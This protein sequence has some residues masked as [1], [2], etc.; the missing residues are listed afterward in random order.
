MKEILLDKNCTQNVLIIN[1]EKYG[2]NDCD[3]DI[4]VIKNMP[5]CKFVTSN[6]S[7]S[8]GK[9]SVQSDTKKAVVQIGETLDS[10]CQK[11]NVSKDYIK[12]KN[13]M[14]NDTIFV[15]QLLEL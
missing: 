8:V 12:Q 2:Y 6:D 1:G 13:N 4:L 5:R 14:K 3:D 15:G 11:Y 9:M 7:R 10:I